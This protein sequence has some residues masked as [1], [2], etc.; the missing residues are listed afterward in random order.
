MIYLIFLPLYDGLNVA[1]DRISEYKLGDIREYHLIDISQ[2]SNLTSTTM[3]LRFKF[4]MREGF[5]VVTEEGK[6]FLLI[7]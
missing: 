2:F 6:F 5:V 7:K 3:S 1:R 4:K